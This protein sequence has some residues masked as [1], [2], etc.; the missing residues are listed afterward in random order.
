MEV[1]AELLLLEVLLGEVLEVP[2]GEGGLGGDVDLGLVAGDGHGIA[3]NANLAVDLDPV[4]EELFL[5]V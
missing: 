5:Q 4:V 2:L 1:V 3:E